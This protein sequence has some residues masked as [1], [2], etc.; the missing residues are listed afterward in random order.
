MSVFVTVAIRVLEAMFFIGGIGATLV[1]I[2]T[3]IEDIETLLGAD[4]SEHH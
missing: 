3:G 4:D 1:L 2:L